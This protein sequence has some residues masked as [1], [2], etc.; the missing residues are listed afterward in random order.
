[1]DGEGR[2]GVMVMDMVTKVLIHWS[3]VG[4]DEN[5]I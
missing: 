4:S 2:D 5:G 3:S 1:M